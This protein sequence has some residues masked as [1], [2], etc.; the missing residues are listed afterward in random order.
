[1]SGGALKPTTLPGGQWCHAA[2]MQWIPE[3]TCL[4]PARMEPIDRIQNIQRE[5]WEL[6]CCVCKQ[7]VGWAVERVLWA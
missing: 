6:L 3:V 2:C 4:D 5:R 7:K 1:M